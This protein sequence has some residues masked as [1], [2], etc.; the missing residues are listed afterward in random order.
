MLFGVKCFGGVK[1]FS[2]DIK[3]V[4]GVKFFRG[5]G[6]KSVVQV[7]QILLHQT[8]RAPIVAEGHQPTARAIVP[9]RSYNPPPRG[10][11]KKGA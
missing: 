4:L 5:G 3:I 7:K 6:K 10:A 9:Q 2:A 11:R 1:K 8:Q